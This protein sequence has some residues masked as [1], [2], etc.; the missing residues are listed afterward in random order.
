MET[1]IEML[2]SEIISR[3][4]FVGSSIYDWN[5]RS[6]VCKWWQQL[7]IEHIRKMGQL[8]YH[9]TT[10]CV[11]DDINTECTFCEFSKGVMRLMITCTVVSYER[12]NE[13]LIMFCAPVDK[14]RELFKDNEILFDAISAK[15]IEPNCLIQFLGV[16]IFKIT[17]IV[18]SIEIS[19]K[20]AN[21]YYDVIYEGGLIRSF[22]IN[23]TPCVSLILTGE[24]C[25][26]V[27][28]TIFPAIVNTFGNIFPQHQKLVSGY[29]HLRDMRDA[30][31]D[32]YI[33]SYYI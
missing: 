15:D 23:N 27:R 10:I 9:G 29:K 26:Y 17:T 11:S 24:C 1:T 13:C 31:H 20:I 18:T 5:H 6:R 2:P 3:I 4:L 28:A 33:N 19:F 7:F 16:E 21:D 30:I 32:T 8:Y 22:S 25:Q 12:K 14:F